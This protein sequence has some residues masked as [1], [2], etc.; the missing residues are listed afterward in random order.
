[1][2]KEEIMVKK[3]T[4]LFKLPE[5]SFY[6]VLPIRIRHA[7]NLSVQ[8]RLLYCELAARCI[9]LPYCIDYDDK[10][11][12]VLNVTEDEIAE[13][14][15]ELRSNGYIKVVNKY[16]QNHRLVERRIYS[17]VTP[18]EAEKGDVL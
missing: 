3:I 10:L 14:I 11:A 18:E 17:V 7:K 13:W 8:A 1:M 4:D 2:T 16:I 15:E 6:G 9:R 12:D 5:S